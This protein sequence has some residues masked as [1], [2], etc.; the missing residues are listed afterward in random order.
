[1]RRIT[2][3]RLEPTGE[4]TRLTLR[5]TVRDRGSVPMVAAGWHICLDLS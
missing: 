2:T 1:V 5:H 3:R 4:G